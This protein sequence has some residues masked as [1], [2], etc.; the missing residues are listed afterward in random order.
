MSSHLTHSTGTL[1]PST[2]HLTI[3]HP[4]PS[5]SYAD[6]FAFR[7]LLLHPTTPTLALSSP[8]DT[9]PLHRLPGGFI[10]S[11]S[12]HSAATRHELEWETG[13]RIALLSGDAVGTTEEWQSVEGVGVRQITVAYVAVLVPLGECEGG[14]EDGVTDE[15]LERKLKLVWVGR[16]EAKGVIEGEEVRTEVG[17]GIRER[18]GFLLERGLRVLQG[19]GL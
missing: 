8:C 5:T 17:V 19:E 4:S 2:P 14:E 18:D 10:P 3:G 7:L 12:N 16:G 1:L 13:G 15:M 6:R 11:L 9:P